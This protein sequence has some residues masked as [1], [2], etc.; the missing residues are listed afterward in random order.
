MMSIPYDEVHTLLSII[1]QTKDLP[2]LAGIAAAAMRELTV[3]HNT[4][5][6]Y[7]AEAKK[8][9]DEEAA[10][11]KADADAKAKAKADAEEKANTS[12]VAKRKVAEDA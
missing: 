7:E 3:H 1:H 5:L 6:K 8:K 10:K 11:L 4:A 12:T 2:K 9:E